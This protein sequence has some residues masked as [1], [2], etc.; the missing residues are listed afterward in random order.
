MRTTLAQNHLNV[1][2]AAPAEM[3][4]RMVDLA[5]NALMR[6]Y[7]ETGSLDHYLDAEDMYYKA[8]EA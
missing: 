6:H 2:Q 1:I 8:K 4:P 7:E 3:K 5:V